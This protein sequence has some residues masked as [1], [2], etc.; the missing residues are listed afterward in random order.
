[1]SK[2]LEYLSDQVVLVLPLVRRPK[3]FNL[4]GELHVDVTDLRWKTIVA[5][6]RYWYEWYMGTYLHEGQEVVLLM[7]PV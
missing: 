3:Q 5:L 7:V 2:E 1:M 6:R 4:S